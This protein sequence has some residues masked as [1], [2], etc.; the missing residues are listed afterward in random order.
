MISEALNSYAATSARVFE[1]RMQTVGASECGQCARKIYWLKNESDPVYGAA[2]DPDYVDNWGARTRGT[3]FE[4]HFWEPALRARFGD[5]LLFAGT[6]QMT[7]TSEF[8]SATPDGLLVNQP[9]D[10]LAAL[11][12]SD[13]GEDGSLVVECKTADPRSSPE[14]AK[15]ENVFQAIV[16]LGLI[17]EL[18]KYRP[19][20]ALI[21]YVDASFWNEI[22]EIPVR[23]DEQIFANAKARAR[24]ILTALSA[25]ELPPEGWIAGGRECKFCPF[26]RACGP[27]RTDVPTR[28]GPEAD[29]QFVAEIADL[30]REAKR[31]EAEGDA[32]SERLRRVQ[33]EI[34]ERLRSRGLNRI[35]GDGVAVTWS[36]VKGRQS[37]DMKAIRE[38]AAAAGIDVEQFSTVGEP[39]DRLLIRITA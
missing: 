34:R 35:T 32:A 39:T 2:R 18:T 27:K 33:H 19:E 12:V 20:Y 9:R 5:D 16:Q 10:A 1:D 6:A 14:K 4:T 22:R 38:A 37:F 36:G 21:S 26:T 29:P 25:E 31:H 23:F 28:A 13:I 30:A 7:F 17:R 8:L 24:R 11:G 3:I 15:G